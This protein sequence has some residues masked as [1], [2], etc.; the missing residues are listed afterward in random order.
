MNKTLGFSFVGGDRRMQWAKAALLEAGQQIVP[1]S[2]CTHLILPLPA[3]RGGTVNGGPPL[4]QILPE[5]P[6]G[7]TV[8]GGLLE[9]HREELLAA[10]LIPVDY[11]LHEPLIAEN[12]RLTAEAAIFL[13]AGQLSVT[14]ENSSVLIAGWGRIGQLLAWKLKALGASVTVSAR[15]PKDLGMI[16]ALGFTPMVT[17]QWED[18]S[19]Y[20]IVYNTIPA[21]VFL[22]RH[23]ETAGED[24]LFIELASR[25]GF[26]EGGSRSIENAPGLPGIYAPETAGRLIGRTILELCHPERR[27]YG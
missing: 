7:T 17:G 5:L 25:P 27:P 6:R 4:S 10:G 11:Y 13:A 19:L 26:P 14:L 20:N 23:M 1:L 16:R 12:A 18:L 24:C 22:P 2:H 9:P 15:S 3:F 8:M 21:P